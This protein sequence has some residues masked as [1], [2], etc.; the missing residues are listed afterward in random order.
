[1]KTFIVGKR[2]A[3]SL[4][5]F[6]IIT[7]LISFL[8]PKGVKMAVASANERKLPIYCVETDKKHIAI[9]FDAAWGNSNTD[10][11]LEIL[12]KHNAKATF[13]FTGEWVSKY[14]DDV[15]KI[16]AAGHSLANHSDKHNHIDKMSS[17]E[18][19]S[20][21]KA[22]NEKIRSLTG[23]SPILYRGPYGEY[24]NTL[25]S[26]LEKVNMYCLQWDIDSRDWQKKSVDYMVKNVTENVKN[27][28]IVL[29]HN[30]LKD[31]EAA[32]DK[33]LE[34]L[35]KEGYSFV[36]ADELIY[37][38]NYKIKPNGQQYKTK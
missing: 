19:C 2:E 29:F 17:E 33:I 38:E 32:L 28:S 23:Y 22:C 6:L 10:S 4:L 18:L 8:A 12:K 30:D 21:I 25:L 35:S 31:T 9:T 13:F 37:K 5:I 26:E 7:V 14:P 16:Y 3:V 15:L 11:L 27:G 24:N 1:M 36:S 20:D 34:T